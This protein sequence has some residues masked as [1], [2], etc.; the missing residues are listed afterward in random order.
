MASGVDAAL[1][2]LG[3]RTSPISRGWKAG[4]VVAMRSAEVVE[5]PSGIAI[6]CW[7]AVPGLAGDR[8]RP[9]RL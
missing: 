8:M 3:G 6:L 5:E 4:G 1:E 9:S 7:I 2:R